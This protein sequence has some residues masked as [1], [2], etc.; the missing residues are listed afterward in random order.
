MVTG[1]MLIFPA[2][3]FHAA[4]HPEDSFFDFPRLTLA[5]WMVG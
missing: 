2:K 1:R 3:Y 5:F 4:F